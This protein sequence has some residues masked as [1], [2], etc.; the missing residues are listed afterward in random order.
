MRDRE[1]H[2]RAALADL[3]SASVIDLAAVRRALADARELRPPATLVIDILQLELDGNLPH[4]LSRKP[5]G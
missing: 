5:D 1:Q 4:W 3:L 2:A